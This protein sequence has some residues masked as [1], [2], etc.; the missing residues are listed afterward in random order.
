MSDEVQEQIS[1]AVPPDEA[2]AAV[3]DVRRIAGWSPEC[4]AV[5][6][7]RRQGTQPERFI[8]WNRRGVYVWF[9]TCRVVTAEPGREFAFDVTTFGQPVSRW[10]YRL[11]PAAGGTLI[12]EYWQDQR[13]QTAT[14]LGRVFTGSVARQRPQAN[15]AGM[16]QTL[17]RLKGEL[18][19]RPG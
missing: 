16:R 13:N 8:G 3:S 10:G 5:W 15:R 17:S 9:T 19:R 11:T 12:T 18:E 7:W 6:V 14:T 1:V 4:F 2:Y